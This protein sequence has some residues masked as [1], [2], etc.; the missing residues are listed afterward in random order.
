MGE[1]C[2][3]LWSFHPIANAVIN[4]LMKA[5]SRFA[6]VVAALFLACSPA[7]G[8]TVYS[9]FNAANPFAHG[10]G[11]KDQG[12]SLVWSN[13]GGV[14]DS[15]APN[16]C[17]YSSAGSGS[18]KA[19]D[20]AGPAFSLDDGISYTVSEEVQ[21][22]SVG[23]TD[24]EVLD[25]ALSRT[26]IVAGDNPLIGLELENQGGSNLEVIPTWQDPAKNYGSAPGLTTQP[27]L[28][29][30]VRLTM[31]IQQTDVATGAFSGIMQV[32]DLGP[33]GAATPVSLLAPTPFTFTDSLLA[34]HAAAGWLPS[35]KT[36]VPGNV[37]DN[38]AA[39]PTP[40][41]GALVAEKGDLLNTSILDTAGPP[42]VD[43]N[44]DVAFHATVT[45]PQHDNRVQS[46]ILLY[47]GTN[48]T[49]IATTGD[50]SN[51]APGTT[52]AVF[53]SV[54]DPALSGSGALA[55]IGTLK[56]GVGDATAANDSGIWVAQS[57]TTNLIV[58]TDGTA[59]T[60]AGDFAGPVTYDSFSQVMVNNAGGIDF[61]CGLHRTGVSSVGL[62]GTDTSGTLQLISAKAPHGVALHGDL[63]V[64]FFPF[65]LLPGV[66]GQS[67]TFDTVYGSGTLL[68]ELD[69]DFSS[70]IGVA[71]T[72]AAGFSE[73]LLVD[74]GGNVPGEPGVHIKSMGEPIIN[75]SNSVAFL[76]GLEGAGISAKNNSGIG[77]HTDAGGSL[78]WQTGDPAPDPSGTTTSGTFTALG[79][80]VLNNLNGVA[81][82]ATARLGA[83]A[84]ASTR[85][86][87]WVEDQ[88]GTTQRYALQGEPAPQG[89][90]F[91]GFSQ[92]VLPDAGG[93]VF[94]ASLSGMPAG[95]TS[96]IYEIPPNG[97]PV[98]I[99]RTGVLM[100]VRSGMKTIKSLQ[101]FQQPP[102]VTGQSRSFDATTGAVVYQAT[103]TDGTW[104][105]YT[106]LPPP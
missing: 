22:N 70:S 100:P 13:T 21:V 87:V 95:Q 91:S 97:Q 28:G 6:H 57:G 48:F 86:G 10:Y 77:L 25:L 35:W 90:E 60:G 39:G 52:G 4:L 105:I 45:D 92:I 88:Y 8:Q 53:S 68:G 64:S 54:S 61:L 18:A 3:K 80:P 1:G 49:I 89:G 84:T 73:S 104:A 106:H 66:A 2:W 29:D 16:G 63:A 20:V 96:G 56:S 101:I 85:T 30:W 46:G 69:P 59:P 79:N 62:Y 65:Q 82:I 27:A 14:L 43:S 37:F 7:I 98:L 42:A 23:A 81:F 99:N 17:V 71:A 93:L 15:A 9:N 76:A 19:A 31:V 67:R 32:D 24:D 11:Q 78:I 33:T 44:L 83:G 51:I 94:E 75:G 58:R 47:S 72:G 12:L 74:V 41:N 5:S 55:F 38:L 26:P 36:T 50:P 40:G 102:Y 34:G 103:F